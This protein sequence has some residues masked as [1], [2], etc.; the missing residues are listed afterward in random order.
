VWL[1]VPSMLSRSHS[2]MFPSAPPD[3]RYRPSHL[4]SAMAFTPT[5]CASV[6]ACWA[7]FAAL[8]LPLVAVRPL[9][10]MGVGC[11]AWRKRVCCSRAKIEGSRVPRERLRSEEFMHSHG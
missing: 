1:P 9:N 8:L 4:S 10:R 6:S 7:S 5:G 3:S 2:L 11:K